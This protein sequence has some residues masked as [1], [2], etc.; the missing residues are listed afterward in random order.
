MNQPLIL[1][2]DMGTQS[3]RAMLV[4]QNGNIVKKAQKRY[5]PPYISRQPGWA[6][7]R[8]EFYWESLCEVSLRLK[9]EAKDLWNNILAVTI[10]SIRDTCVCVDSDGKPLRDAILW[11]DKRDA[12][13]LPKIPAS[14]KAA[15]CAVGMYDSVKLQRRMSACNW[16][17][18]NEPDIWKKTYKFLML[19]T[20]LKYRMIGQYV[21][22]CADLIGHIPFD[23]KGRRWMKVNDMKRC[24]FEIEPEKLYSV[25][26]PGEVMGRVT[27][28]ASEET[29]IPEGFELIATGSDKG[30][31][32]LG[33]SCFEKTKAAL[34]FGTTATVQITTDF[35]MEPLPFIPA[36][37]AVLKNCYNPEVQISRGYWLVS[38]FK[39]EFGMKETQEAN[40]LGISPEELLNRRLKE[41][42]AGCDGLVLQP[43][44]TPGITMPK[45]KGAVIGF[46]DVH[47]RIHI[48]R[49]ILEGINFALMD[50][51]RTME[52]RGGLKV[53]D[54]YVAGGGS[55]SDEICQI[56]ANMFGLPVHRIQTHEVS[57]L[58][59]SMIA[60]VSKGVFS[61]IQDAAESMVHISST[62]VPDMVEHKLYKAI[63]NEIFQKI[64]PRLIPLYKKH[65]E[66]KENLHVT[67]IPRL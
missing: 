55:Q 25:V 14:T 10:T 12:H 57:G 38:W 16:I 51:L 31:E 1:T 53:K 56:T 66:I 19:S 49:A 17:R 24:I 6:E 21:D 36:Y 22:S 60:F 39:R 27:Q 34:S 13:G 59:S 52:K 63:Y 30:C 58:G 3:A 9:E 26:E 50:G 37:P 29:G 11:V 5:E 40:A 65:E 28:K 48:Y 15:F 2:F 62:F 33:L 61:N 7:Q 35:Y 4:D 18:V 54:L 43:Y 23:S 47:T 45:A 44:F 67:S 42:P 20:Y 41:I 64:F 32:T 46:S 8:A